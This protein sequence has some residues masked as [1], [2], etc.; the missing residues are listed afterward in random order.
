MTTIG[1]DMAPAFRAKR[2]KQKRITL[3][4]VREL[5][6]YEDTAVVLPVERARGRLAEMQTAALV[7]QLA[8]TH[9]NSL[10]FYKRAF[11]ILCGETAS[12]WYAG[13]MG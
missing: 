4:A 1:T 8:E 10:P 12:S 7:R 9:W 11:L 13:R 2:R 6:R 5:R 3:K